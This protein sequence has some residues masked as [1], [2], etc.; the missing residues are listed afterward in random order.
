VFN[1]GEPPGEGFTSWIW[2]L[3][4]A[5]FHYTGIDIIFISKVLGI[6]FHLLG[7][8]VLFL[9]VIKLLGSDFVSKITAGTLTFVFCLN[10]RLIAHSVSGMET[11]LYVFSI[12]LLTYLTTRALLAAH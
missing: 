7:G 1:P 3:F 6:L 8:A 10:Y 4:L 9:L 5:F 11:S 2:L 12:I